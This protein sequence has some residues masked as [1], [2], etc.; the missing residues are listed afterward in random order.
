MSDRISLRGL[1]KLIWFDTL[2]RVHNVGFLVERLK[3]FVVDLLP[4]D[5]SGYLE[6][7][8]F[9]F[10]L[11]MCSNDPDCFMQISFIILSASLFIST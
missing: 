10:E 2:R 1:R 3:C 8:R 7:E 5:D 9:S 11:L 4:I 6:I